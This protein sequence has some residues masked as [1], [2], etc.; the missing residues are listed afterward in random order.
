MGFDFLLVSNPEGG[1]LAG[2]LRIGDQL[3]SLDTAHF[4]PQ[5]RGFLTFAGQ[6]Y[7]VASTPVNQGEENI[8][9]LSV[10]ERFDFSDF[11]TPAVLTQNGKVLKSS[12][13]GIPLEEVES[14]F[15]GCQGQA[16]CE[17]RLRA[18]TY[19]SLPLES[20][21]FGQGYLLRSLQS[22]DSANAPVQKILRRVFL[23]TGIGTLLATVI[24]S[25]LS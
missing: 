10:G 25:V 21:N 20:I 5:Q 17:L 2:V 11:S 23:I 9:I 18:E 22:I 7:Q 3:V 14:A 1:P 13:P 15:K 6:A 19:V 24:L 12:I 4:Q 8:G 16:E